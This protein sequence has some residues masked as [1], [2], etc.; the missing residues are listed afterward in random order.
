MAARVSQSRTHRFLPQIQ[1]D[2]TAYARSLVPAQE[3]ENL[4]QEVNAALLAAD[5][6]PLDAGQLLAYGKGTMAKMAPRSMKRQRREPVKEPELAEQTLHALP[7]GIDD[8]RLA[9][10]R[11][12]EAPTAAQAQAI[13]MVGELLQGEKMA[14]VA[15]RAG[16]SPETAWK[17]V[18]RVTPWLATVLVL[19]LVGSFAYWQWKPRI[20]VSPE[21]ERFQPA[22]P[23]PQE[24]AARDRDAA[25]VLYTQGNLE[26]S[27]R[28]LDEAQ[29]LDPDGENDPRVQQL[30]EAVTRAID[31]QERARE[32]KPLR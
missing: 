28:L 15:A 11:T 26:P 9:R 8:A 29:D 20:E 2:L 30:R 21:P 12:L 7:S 1:S 10:L 6:E 31:E 3:V 19:L 14:D 13:G 32:G 16:L 23:T 22:A 24:I 5:F 17:R 18:H 27:I 25:L 4:V